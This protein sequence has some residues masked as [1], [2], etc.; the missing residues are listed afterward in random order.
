V[1]DTSEG[2]VI[3]KGVTDLVVLSLLRAA[4]TQAGREITRGLLGTILRS[5]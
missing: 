2:L 1:T 3:A 5:R 4:G